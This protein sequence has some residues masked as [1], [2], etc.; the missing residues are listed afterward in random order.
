VICPACGARNAAKAAW[1][2]QC[3]APLGAAADTDP[4]TGVREPDVRER[5]IRERDVRE[6]DVRERDG[7]VEW[8]C[9]ACGGWT[10]LHLAACLHCASPRRGFGEAATPVRTFPS[11]G[12]VVLAASLV[13]P[14]L[15]HLLVGRSGT[16]L[17]RIVL[18]VLWVGGGL[19][20]VR[21]GGGGTAPGLILLAGALVLWLATAVDAR[22][23][24]AGSRTELLGSRALAVLVAV[25]TGGLVLATVVTAPSLS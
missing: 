8:R 4:E 6:R 7:E 18:A 20:L 11:G 10:P 16:G 3:Y 19:S 5:D 15:G 9:G 13:L 14:G 24:A 22:Y 1:C 2:S 21:N 17:A 25:V 23:L 12:G